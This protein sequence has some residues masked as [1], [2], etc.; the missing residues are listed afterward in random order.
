MAKKQRGEKGGPKIRIAIAD[1][2][3]LFL[4]GLTAALRNEEGVMVS[5]TANN[6]IEFLEKLKTKTI[7]IA[8]LDLD[9]PDMDGKEVLEFLLKKHPEIGV[10]FI[11]M[12]VNLEIAGELINMGAKSYLKKNSSVEELMNAIFNVQEKGRH[13]SD[14]VN[15]SMS[16]KIES[17][18]RRAE[19]MAYFNFSEREMLV[20]RLICSGSTSEAIGSRLELSKKSIDRVRSKLYRLLK[21]KTTADFARIC[22]EKGLYQ[23]IGRV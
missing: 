15:E 14:I 4:E 18:K 13:F 6:G 1:D 23:P 20:I 11:S 3:T 10:I 12:H 21:A 19:A 22:I 5:F 8:L 7:D 2:H 17:N 9:M 16:L